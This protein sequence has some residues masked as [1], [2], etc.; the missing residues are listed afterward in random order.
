MTKATYSIDE[1]RLRSA[2]AQGDRE[3]E[4]VGTTSTRDGRDDALLLEQAIGAR[5]AQL[6]AQRGLRAVELAHAAG[7]ATPYVWRV[8][9]GRQNMTVRTLDK[10]A[11]ALGVSLSELLAGI[12]GL[13]ASSSRPPA[14]QPSLA[15]R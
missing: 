8:E 1:Q 12:G 11:G 5:I 3:P 7:L 13:E 15:E 10:I 14:Q 6:R 2:T 9:H 4:Y